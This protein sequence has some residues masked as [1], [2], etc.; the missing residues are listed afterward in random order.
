[1]AIINWLLSLRYYD[2]RGCLPF[3]SIGK[4][5][6]NGKNGGD[7]EYSTEKIGLVYDV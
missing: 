2:G 1:M 7:L 5:N 3:D 6:L 4:K